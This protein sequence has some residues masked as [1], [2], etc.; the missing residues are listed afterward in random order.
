MNL[1]IAELNLELAPSHHELAA[2][3]LWSEENEIADNLFRL[4][5]G[6]QLPAACTHATRVKPIQRRSYRFL[7][8]TFDTL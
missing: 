5:P 3:H 1:L 2:T 8:A 4:S 6:G 7:G